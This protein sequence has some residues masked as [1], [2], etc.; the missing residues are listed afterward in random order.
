LEYG[1]ARQEEARKRM[2]ACG[3]KPSIHTTALLSEAHYCTAL[4]DSSAITTLQVKY[5]IEA[6][7]RPPRPTFS[8]HLTGVKGIQHYRKRGRTIMRRG[9]H[10]SIK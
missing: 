1:A 4:I 6:T 7:S 3:R 5:E 9:C 10:L 2:I 8:T